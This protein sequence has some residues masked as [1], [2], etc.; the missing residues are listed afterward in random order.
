MKFLIADD[1]DDLREIISFLITS[2]YDVHVDEAMNGTQAVEFLDSR[3]PYDLVL[4]DYNMPQKNGGD[5]YLHLRKHSPQTPFILVSTDF[6]KF[7]KQM[8]F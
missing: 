1:D 7:K 4:C 3:G 6:D 2:N 8:K 5:V